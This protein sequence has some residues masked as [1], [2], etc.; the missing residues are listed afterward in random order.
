M[1]RNQKIETVIQKKRML[2]DEEQAKKLKK[3]DQYFEK[4]EKINYKKLAAQVNSSK[5]SLI[6]DED[7]S[8]NHT[9]VDITEKEIRD[10]LTRY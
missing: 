7:D 9:V 10:R 2:E 6:Y 1:K 8:Q 4:S 5:V 3:L